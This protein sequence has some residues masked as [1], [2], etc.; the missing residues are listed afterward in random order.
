MTEFTRRQILGAPLAAIAPRKRYSYYAP[1]IRSTV[2]EDVHWTPARPPV[3]KGEQF[4]MVIA[5]DYAKRIYGI[6]G[7]RQAWYKDFELWPRGMSLC[8][9]LLY[10]IDDPLI[11]A[12]DPMT[13]VPVLKIEV[14]GYHARLNAVHVARVFGELRLTLC[15]DRGG[16]TTMSPGESVHC[17]RLMNGILL[18]PYLCTI[19]SIHPRDACMT[20]AGQLLVADTFGNQVLLIDPARD[21]L[22]SVA[23]EYFP[24]S[25]QELQDGWVLVCSEHG[26]R[27]IRWNPS[28]S[29]RRMIF[30][31]PIYPFNDI[32]M[33]SERIRELE[34]GTSDPDSDVAPARSLCAIQNAGLATLYSPNSARQRDGAILVADTDNHRVIVLRD[35]SIVT[36]VTGLN[37]PVNA[38]WL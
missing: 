18:D 6:I 37:N 12:L 29:E 23:D 9:G 25:V 13:G 33:G 8:E 16:D 28:T 34:V 35:G 32:R 27:V 38:V 19:N 1:A 2:S 30:S 3:M 22:I 31:A 26:N 17:F 10:V 7:G 14:P 4:N 11:V 20:R 21:E 36:D 24:N 15:F 5:C